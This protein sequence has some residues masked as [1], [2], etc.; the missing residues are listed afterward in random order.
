MVY[1]LK[2]DLDPG[3]PSETDPDPGVGGGGEG[4]YKRGNQHKEIQR[5]KERQIEKKTSIC[6]LTDRKRTYRRRK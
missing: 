3:I 1:F 5:Q 6:T 4:K 2:L